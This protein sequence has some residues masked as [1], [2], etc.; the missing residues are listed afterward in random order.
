[1]NVSWICTMSSGF[2][3]KLEA[4]CVSFVSFFFGGRGVQDVSKTTPPWKS[5]S[6]EVAK[7]SQLES[8]RLM[9]LRAGEALS[10]Q[11]PSPNGLRLTTASKDGFWRC[12]KR[13]LLRMQF[14][15]GSDGC[16]WCMELGVCCYLAVEVNASVSFRHIRGAFVW[17]F[18]LKMVEVKSQ[19]NKIKQVYI[20]Y[21]LYSLEWREFEWLSHFFRC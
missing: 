1:M 16:I 19:S 6:A 10:S 3:Y 20:Y 17:L 2:I 9:T 7:G 15:M 13:W 5:R 18:R 8:L 4:I 14:Q 12:S 21:V 11:K